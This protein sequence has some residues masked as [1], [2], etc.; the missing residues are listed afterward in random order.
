MNLM[1][2]MSQISLSSGR[3]ATIFCNESS[4]LVAPTKT[5][6]PFRL[7]NNYNYSSHQNKFEDDVYVFVC[8]CICGVRT[9][10]RILNVVLRVCV[11]VCVCICGRAVTSL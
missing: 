3:K 11:C 10:L 6:S 8:E 2:K 1:S 4:T 9:S 5:F 7:F